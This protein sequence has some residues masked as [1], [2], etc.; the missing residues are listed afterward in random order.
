MADE[1]RPV[2]KIELALGE[3]QETLLI[4]LYGAADVPDLLLQL[5]AHGG[6][7]H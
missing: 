4:P 1:V 5:P 6:L 7:S 3:V 2:T